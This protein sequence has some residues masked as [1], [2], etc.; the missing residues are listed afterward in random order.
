MPPMDGIRRTRYGMFVFFGWFSL[1]VFGV[2]LQIHG[3]VM[4]LA[5]G[6]ED[7][8]GLEPAE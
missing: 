8:V 1:A 3:R 4:E 5:A 2:V 6:H 7:L